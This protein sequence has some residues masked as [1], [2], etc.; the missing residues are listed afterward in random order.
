MRWARL[1]GISLL[2]VGGA[3]IGASVATGEGRVSLVVVVPVFWAT[4]ALGL[5]GVGALFL[6][7]AVL[8][9]SGPWF[10]I[11]PSGTPSVSTPPP[12]EPGATGA[13]SASPRYGGLIVV[14]PFPVAFGTD[15]QLAMWMLVI[16]M[17]IAAG[18]V[19]FTLL[20]LVNEVWFPS[21]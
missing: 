15:R 10:Q 6:G 5:L 12:G 21:P 17:V 1:L 3:L 9:F 11:V 7:F 4:S 20:Y 16:G 18:F 14:G 19:M 8:L 2:I 13:K